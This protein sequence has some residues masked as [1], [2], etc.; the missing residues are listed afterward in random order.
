[1]ILIIRANTS[2]KDTA[3]QS[4]IVISIDGASTT[5]SRPEEMEVLRCF[6][7]VS[8]SGVDVTLLTIGPTVNY[9]TWLVFVGLRRADFATE[10][11]LKKRV[12]LNKGFAE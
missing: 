7:K 12:N 9:E 4:R 11:V 10:G 8:G 2:A 1:M 3:I 6:P 5:F